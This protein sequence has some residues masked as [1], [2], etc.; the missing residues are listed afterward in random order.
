VNFA[1]G[2]EAR[3]PG[4]AGT[5]N[6]Q[7]FA[8]KGL[9]GVFS[10]SSRETPLYYGILLLRSPGLYTESAVEKYAMDLK[11][12]AAGILGSAVVTAWHIWIQ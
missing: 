1:H 3:L 7:A 6:N 9:G 10:N 5:A 11:F 8:H 12:F 4:N 2:S